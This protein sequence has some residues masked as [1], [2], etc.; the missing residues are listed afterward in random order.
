MAFLVLIHVKI[1]VTKSSELESMVMSPYDLMISHW[2]LMSY[3]SS[4]S[5]STIYLLV[6]S[7]MQSLANDSIAMVTVGNQ[8]GQHH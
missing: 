1:R 7:M 2:S 5:A 4:T 6:N 3:T 8:F